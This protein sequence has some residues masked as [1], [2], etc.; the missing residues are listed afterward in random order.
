MRIWI[1]LANSP[2]VPFFAALARE[3][4][5][6]GHAVEFTAR[7]YAQTVELAVASLECATALRRP[8]APAPSR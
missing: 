6:R 2:H 1:D 5:R 3:F 8:T 7:G 4:G